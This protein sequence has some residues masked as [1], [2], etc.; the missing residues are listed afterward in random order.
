ME[1]IVEIVSDLSSNGLLLKSSIKNENIVLLDMHL[2]IGDLK[3]LSGLV[4]V[5]L[6]INKQVMILND[7]SYDVSN[8]HAEGGALVIINDSDKDISL[9]SVTAG[10]IISN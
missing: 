2:D 6:D 1:N 9:L 3:E 10:E 5:T 8:I 4:K 7:E